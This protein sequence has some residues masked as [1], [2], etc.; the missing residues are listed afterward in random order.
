MLTRKLSPLIAAQDIHWSN[1]R[2]ISVAT[3]IF[4]LIISVV[5]FSNVII[6]LG[7]R[8]LQEDWATQR[9]SE[10]QTVGTL[11]AD[12]VSFQQFRTQMFARSELLRRYLDVPSAVRQDK[13]EN[14]W[15]I[16]TSNIP[17]LLDIALFDPQGN[18]KFATSDNFG[19]EPLPPSLLGGSRNMGGNEIYTSPLEFSPVNGKL[20]PYLYQLAWL[21]NPDQSVRG[22]LV[23][24]NSMSKMLKSINPAYSTSQSPLLMLDTQGLLYTGVDSRDSL[25][26]IPDTMGGSLKQSYPALWRK[27]AMSNFGQFHG[28]NATFVYLK[29][30]LTTQ[31]ETRREYFL[32]SYVRNDD[33]AANFSQWRVILIG[34]ATMLTLLASLLILLSHFYRLE[35]RS[36]AFSIELTNRLFHRETGAII[37]N[38]NSRVIAANALAAQQLATPKDELFDRSLQRILQLE[39]DEYSRITSQLQ[40][41]NEW[42]GELNME[43]ETQPKLIAH[44]KTEASKD[45]REVYLLITFEDVSAL[46]NAQKEA[47]LSKALTDSAVATA[48]IQADGSII[49]AN[50]AFEQQIQL[51]AGCTS[52][53]ET[54]PDDLGSKWTQ[55]SQLI[56][57]QGTWRGQVLCA[58]STNACLQATLKGHTDTSGELDYI[59]CTFE[60][61]TIK[62]SHDDSGVLVPHR[63]TI[64][65]NFRDLESYFDSLKQSS[66]SHSSL[67]LLDI[68]AENMLSHMSDIG[69][70]ESRQKEV[71]ILLLRELP[72]TYQM[73]HWQLGKL[74]FILPDTDADQAHHFAIKSLASLND[75]GLGEGICMG[76]AAF[77]KGQNLEQYLSNAE[78]A[79]KRAKQIGEQNICQAFTR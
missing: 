73:S 9:Y 47:Y 45:D 44:I 57:L 37:V 70:L 43:S 29:V 20:E 19:H 8:R 42:K 13:L 48:L 2:L 69:Q 66:K 6:T 23:T 39:D 41:K 50:P 79:L 4:I 78:V 25:K 49:R 65:V 53:I 11:I 38:H 34:C 52:L 15:N 74:I 7:E 26:R 76:I 75:M 77:Q 27:M 51:K 12:K 56:Q 5:L 35:Q 54:L 28:D 40:Q 71:E 21:E 67:L 62:N 61:A 18:F 36:R 32:V 30:E 1:Q 31:Y 58:S 24:Y 16:I 10:L 22:Y 33:I 46:K 64:L 72:A 3:Q 14:N 63:S 17:E 59:V 55:I 68:T 60:Q